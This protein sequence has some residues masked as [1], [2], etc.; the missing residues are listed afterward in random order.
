[1]NSYDDVIERKAVDTSGQLGSL[2]D[3]LRDRVTNKPTIS[4]LDNLSFQPISECHVATGA[5][6]QFLKEIKFDDTLLQNLLLGM[7]E[8]KGVSTLVDYHGPIDEHTHFL[9]YLYK[10]KEESFDIATQQI[11]RI[12]IPPHNLNTATHTITKIVWG[13]EILCIIQNPDHQ[14]TKSIRDLLNRLSLQL[15]NC[16]ANLQLS[17]DD[18][19]L[20]E[21]L[22]NVTMFGTERCFDNRTMSLSRI[23]DELPTWPQNHMVYH[24]P[25]FYTICPLNLIYPNLHFPKWCRLSQQDQEDIRAIEPELICLHKLIV[26]LKRTFKNLPQSIVHLRV[27]RCANYI[28]NEYHNILRRCEGSQEAIRDLLVSSRQGFCSYKDI[29]NRIFNRGSSSGDQGIKQLSD[30]AERWFK[31]IELIEKLNNDQVNYSD[32]L[33]IVKSQTTKFSLEDIFNQLEHHFSTQYDSVIL[34]YSN[35]RLKR[36][37][38]SEW[39]KIYQDLLVRKQQIPLI[40]VDFTDN[41]SRL[42]DFHTIRLTREPKSSSDLHQG[43]SL[44]SICVNLLYNPLYFSTLLRPLNSFVLIKFRSTFHIT[45]TRTITIARTKMPIVITT[46][47]N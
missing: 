18:K 7:I 43:K 5:A 35:D 34:W 17:P 28:T 10:H 8:P 6:M 13:F 33:N 15:R 40:Y 4:G 14:C 41:H 3:A 25:L 26:D 1:M 23:L 46:T 29:Y 12:V 19:C 27:D 20:I 44:D 31:K 11:E 36:E 30:D 32:V 37:K 9:H 38:S 47:Q 16:N 45:T 42:N 2:Y 21:K 24:Q 39:E 22:S